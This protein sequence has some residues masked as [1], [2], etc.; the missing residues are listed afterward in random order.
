MSDEN[1]EPYT[2]RSAQARRVTDSVEEPRVR[3]PRHKTQY[4]PKKGDV[5]LKKALLRASQSNNPAMPSTSVRSQPSSS[6]TPHRVASDDASDYRRVVQLQRRLHAE[7]EGSWIEEGDGLEFQALLSRLAAASVGES[8]TNLNQQ[9]NSWLQSRWSPYD[10]TNQVWTGIPAGGLEATLYNPLVELLTTILGKFKLKRRTN[11]DKTVFGN[12]CFVNTHNV[13]LEHNPFDTPEDADALKT[14]P[15][16]LLMG[17]GPSATAF[18]KVPGPDGLGYDHDISIWEGKPDNTF[19]PEQQNQIAVYARETFIAQP[20]RRFVFATMISFTGVRVMRFDRAGCYHTRC[21]D[22]HTNA[23]LFVKIVLALSSYDEKL[24]GYDTSVYWEKRAKKQRKMRFTPTHILENNE[25]VPNAEELVFDLE[26]KPLFARRTIRSRGTVC[27][28]AQYDEREFVVKDYWR[29]DGRQ[30]ESEFLRQLI[31]VPGVAQLFTFVDD[32]DDV[33]TGRGVTQIINRDNQPIA[34]RFLMRV[35]I[36]LYG[37]TLEAA[38]TALE[39]LV[40]IRDIVHGHREC[41]LRHGILHRDISHTN[42]RLSP[43]HERETAVLI[44]WDLAKAIN[45]QQMTEGD[46][47]TGTRAFQSCKVLRLASPTQTS[48]QTA[49]GFPDHMDD[50][51]SVYYVLF[52]ILC[53]FDTTGSRLTA[54][55]EPIVEWFEVYDDSSSLAN[56]KSYFLG[57][58]FF[59][60]LTR[61]PS[62]APVLLVLMK[63]LQRI[64]KERA[65]EADM[66]VHTG[67]ALPKTV[68]EDDYEAFLSPLEAAI[69]QLKAAAAAAAAAPRES[70]SESS[71]DGSQP[72]STETSTSRS[73]GA[74]PASTRIHSTPGKR[75]RE[76]DD[77]DSNGE[78]RPTTPDSDSEPARKKQTPNASPAAQPVGSLL[79]RPDS[80]SDAHSPVQPSVRQRNDPASPSAGRAGRTSKLTRRSSLRSQSNTG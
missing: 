59:W 64:F 73:A 56:L 54:A 23:A 66:A 22:Y 1:P 20:N 63:K 40:A 49:L 57:R 16:I 2:R 44:D 50:L 14:M 15:D 65:D 31:D 12:R 25:L 13:A 77:A 33:C 5:P 9:I 24:V 70:G 43:Y 62:E 48:D 74:A 75:R 11:A 38:S 21:I 47:R 71:A 39:L 17:T 80:H 26:A 28:V 60:T 32:V 18:V 78:Q 67:Q 36:P 79:L 10:A 27:W 41:V 3:R 55:P 68:A 42:L 34:N 61:Y 52:Y 45:G 35:V 37:D 72:I 58:P 46:W 69:Q 53:Y 19:G 29:A 6:S 8:E 76:Y 7:L 51:E 30:S 4:P